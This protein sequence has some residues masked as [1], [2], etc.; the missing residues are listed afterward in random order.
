MIALIVG[1]IVA[2]AVPALGTWWIVALQAVLF[3]VADAVL[4]WRR[5]RYRLVPARV[6]KAHAA[7]L[8][9]LEFAALVEKRTADAVALLLFVSEAERYVEILVDRGIA[10]RVG[11]GEWRAVIADFVAA[12]AAGHVAAALTGAIEAATRL[13]EPHFPPRPA[14]ENALPDRVA[15]IGP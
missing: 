4:H 6:R 11:E 7:R 8:A 3:V 5:L 10:A 13:L 15:E 9:R 14:G 1:D 2:L 12:V